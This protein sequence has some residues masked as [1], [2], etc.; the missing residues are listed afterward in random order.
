MSGCTSAFDAKR[1]LCQMGDGGSYNTT[2]AQRTRI[3]KRLQC[4]PATRTELERE[5][6][7]P[8]VTKRIAELRR[9][10]WPILSPWTAYTAPDGSVSG[11]VLYTLGPG[12]AD[13]A[14]MALPLEP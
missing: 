5:C 13:A 1:A 10:G 4:G 6:W 8:S 12:T 3:L 14:Q 7:A 2:A 9:E 11:A